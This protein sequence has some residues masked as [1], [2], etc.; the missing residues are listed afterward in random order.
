MR[1][2]ISY[3]TNEVV[4]TGLRTSETTGAMIDLGYGEKLTVISTY[5][6]SNSTNANTHSDLN[7]L[8]KVLKQTSYGLICDDFNARHQQWMDT[9]N[10]SEGKAII[11]WLDSN[12]ESHSMVV[13][14]NPNQHSLEHHQTLDFFLSPSSLLYFQVSATL[15]SK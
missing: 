14:S 12:S 3:N 6:K 5:F 4:I 1:E 2:K 9:T 13:V 15:L 10:S 11:D 8:N 7:T